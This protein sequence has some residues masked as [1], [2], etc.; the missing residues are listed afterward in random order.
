[1]MKQMISKVEKIVKTDKSR[2]C[3]SVTK[4]IAHKKYGDFLDESE[5]QQVYKDV[6]LSNKLYNKKTQ[7]WFDK[8]LELYTPAFEA[9]VLTLMVQDYDNATKENCKSNN[10]TE[11]GYHPVSMRLPPII[12]KDLIKECKEMA[13]NEELQITSTSN[14]VRYFESHG[15][16]WKESLAAGGIARFLLEPL[17]HINILADDVKVCAV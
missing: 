14:Q 5:K 9:E 16:E 13:H 12:L 3:Q 17:E 10:W 2:A 1:M 8:F 4:S 7:K 11:H 6:N 15:K